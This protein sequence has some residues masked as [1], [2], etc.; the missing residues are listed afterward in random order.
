MSELHWSHPEAFWL[1]L[2]V[3]AVF[4]LSMRCHRLVRRAAHQFVG[5]T[6]VTRLCPP[7]ST[8]PVV[9]RSL[10]LSLSFALLVL[11][12]ARPGWGYDIVPV[13]TKG[14]DLCV[15]LDLSRSMLADD[16]GESRLDRAKA[17]VTSLVEGMEGDRV[18]LLYFAGEVLP[19]CPLTFDR[20]FLLQALRQASPEMVGR[21]G[22][23][24]GPAL[25]A[26]GALLDDQSG[27]ES[28]IV[29]VTDAG[30]QDT[31]PLTAASDLK[32][33]G[34]RVVTV[35]VG[36][37]PDNPDSPLVLS[38]Q[39]VRRKDGT[40]VPARINQEL[41]LE[42]AKLT[43][44]VYVPPEQLFRLREIYRTYVDPLESDS[45]VTFEERRYRERYRWFVFPG[46]LLALFVFL[47]VP[48]RGRVAAASLCF[49][50]L[51]LPSCGTDKDTERTEA[52]RRQWESED[53]AGALRT[54][55]EVL[56]SRGD[57]PLPLL[58]VGL[59]ALGND[60]RD[61]ARRAFGKVLESGGSS[62]RAQA[63]MG[64]ARLDLLDLL[65]LLP[66]DVALA[67][68][69][70]R[71]AIRRGAELVL[72]RY[73]SVRR[74]DEARKD[75]VAE[76]TQVSAWL[77]NQE[78][79]WARADREKA[80]NERLK[81][82][83]LALLRALIKDGDAAIAA[84]NQGD[85]IQNA[86][87]ILGELSE[88]CAT[89]RQ[90]LDAEDSGVPKA[91]KSE[92]VTLATELGPAFL[93]V[94]RSL[95]EEDLRDGLSAWLTARRVAHRL[96]A[97][98]ADVGA[99]LLTLRS[100]SQA[101]LAQALSM[102]AAVSSGVMDSREFGRQAE[103]WEMRLA[104]LLLRAPG[105][106]EAT[107]WPMRFASLLGERLL[108]L[109]AKLTEFAKESPGDFDAWQR[110]QAEFD[111][112][113][114]FLLREW[115]LGQ[116]KAPDL[117]LALTEEARGLKLKLATGDALSWSEAGGS[118]SDPIL[119]L[120][121]RVA[122][123]PAAIATHLAPQSEEANESEA[124][125]EQR[126]VQLAQMDGRVNSLKEIISQ[127]AK[128][129]QSE[130]WPPS[131]GL[132]QDLDRARQELFALGMELSPL[133][134]VLTSLLAA[135]R[136]LLRVGS[137]ASGTQ[138]AHKDG[139][140]KAL[141]LPPLSLRD[142]GIEQSM[143]ES[144]IGRLLSGL[145]ELSSSMQAQTE[146]LASP[147]LASE[148]AKAKL[149]AVEAMM[150]P[151]RSAHDGAKQATGALRLGSE[152]LE[153]EGV[154]R[155]LALSKPEQEKVADGLS[156]ALKIWQEA[157]IP[158]PVLAKG[159]MDLAQS[160]LPQVHGLADLAASDATQAEEAKQRILLDW[161]TKGLG[162]KGRLKPAFERQRLLAAEPNGSEQKSEEELAQMAQAMEQLS[163]QVDQL[164]LAFDTATSPLEQGDWSKSPEGF[165]D[166]RDRARDLW[167]PFAELKALLESAVQ[168]QTSVRDRIAPLTDVPA[169]VKESVITP[170]VKGQSYVAQ[171][172][173]PVRAAIEAQ[174]GGSGGGE[175][176]LSEEF[177]ALA[178]KNLPEAE[179][180]MTEVNAG[181]LE[182]RYEVS[183]QK[184]ETARRLLQELLDQ[185]N[186]DE[187][188]QQ[189]QNQP[190]PQPEQGDSQENP[191]DDGASD[192]ER[193]RRAVEEA[194]KKKER[195]P[196][197]QRYEVEE[198]W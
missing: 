24:I 22:T 67:K 146:P 194:N 196:Q 189:D 131:E 153:R 144:E 20:G 85:L 141:T 148:E 184:A 96:L 143:V 64:L 52:A 40:P 120:A 158:F 9:V 90:S 25:L 185:L 155:A 6:M 198:D 102:K 35:G 49:A 21:G 183:E 41:L 122:L 134:R 132:T 197:T 118:L 73:Q 116:M 44:G 78:D 50:V 18:A 26:A 63:Q 48:Y 160:H 8:G 145:P 74:L 147:T 165:S 169:P 108:K 5:E 99:V 15:V 187:Q 125:L 83:G 100:E 70:E 107:P 154:L 95:E 7:L 142:Q 174:S 98:W 166:V 43:E 113:V 103:D 81:N 170:I 105:A 12:F 188:E 62:L 190:E 60:E 97:C 117:A 121:D 1:L 87:S 167:I 171:W 69:K 14:V 168:D 82:K 72:D 30:D 11:G 58:N 46:F 124:V 110:L 151:L 192:L 28:V 3:P 133:D 173:P 13:D 137:E 54:L 114:N 59:A 47:R 126:K 94:S 156:Q 57:E 177:L 76:Q 36:R 88:D 4:G 23:Q 101:G 17:A 140:I 86:A 135:Q 162:F 92:A 2:F 193:L 38:G 112:D 51:L 42:M 172:I 182:R 56:D 123:L 164:T 136:L 111:A 10:L 71:E 93:A 79:A 32:K 179:N 39:V 191:S 181:L 161:N 152:H 163:L 128:R 61:A 34:I 45:G 106:E 66:K 115:Q 127:S 149:A 119:L 75:A 180:A 104:T 195:R 37:T 31:F 175:A 109:R 157:L 65:D 80:R 27:R 55:R 176:G 129:L 19:A 68:E 53:R 89:V 138:E 186:Q 159:M 16:G 150:P 84:V 33:R 29:V 178:D 130:G 77:R 91:S 139:M